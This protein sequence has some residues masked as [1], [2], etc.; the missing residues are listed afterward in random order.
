LGGN[1]NATT[2]D[3]SLG[4]HGTLIENGKLGTAVSEMNIAGNMKD[5]WHRLVEVGNDPYKYS[6]VL[7]PSLFFDAW[8]FAGT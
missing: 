3:F 8:Q 6:S 1:S 4:V 7:V 5:L 2:G